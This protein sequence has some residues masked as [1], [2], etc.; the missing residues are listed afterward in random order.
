MMELYLA[1]RKDKVWQFA[2][3]WMELEG[4]RICEMSNTTWSHAD[5]E[6]KEARGPLET[7]LEISSTALGT[8]GGEGIRESWTKGTST[9]M[10]G[11]EVATQQ[12][13]N[14]TFSC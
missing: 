4:V 6:E 2:A 10:G 5:V 12:E 14:S 3:C 8:K 9:V 11:I 13:E 7:S 1:T